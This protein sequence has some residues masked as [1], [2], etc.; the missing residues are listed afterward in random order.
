MVHRAPIQIDAS[1]FEVQN[2]SRVA[3][4]VAMYGNTVLDVQ[5]VGQLKN[6]KS[7]APLFLAIGGL[8]LVAGAGIFLSEVKQDWSGYQEKMA[9]AN[10]TGGLRPQK[11]GNGLGGL[12][13]ALALLGVV[14]F[15]MGLIRMGDFVNRSYTIGE[16]HGASF[17]VPPQGLPDG[18]AFPLVRGSDHEFSLNFTQGMTGEVTFDG[19]S[20]PLG[21][22]VSSGRA[23]STGSSYTF[24]LPPGR[25]LPRQVQR[26][27]LLRELGRPG[28][29]DQG[30][31]RHRQA[32]LVLQR[33]LVRRDRL[34][35]G[36]H[37]PDP[38]RGR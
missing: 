12:G 21:Q 6:K 7:Q 34:A 4:V 28:R 10:E 27:H 2:G 22:L 24:P 9:E 3:E 30:R 26:R 35:A 23:G 29:R 32:V 11:P 25:Q 37:A 19:Q 13:V 33:R 17:H 8:M 18:G 38:Q 16:S 36:A 14:P 1:E 20:I 5:H 31:Q 15:G